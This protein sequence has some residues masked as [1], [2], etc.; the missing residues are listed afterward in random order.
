MP[1]ADGREDWGVTADD[2]G[3]SFLGQSLSIDLTCNDKKKKINFGLK[4]QSIMGLSFRIKK[5]DTSQDAKS[6]LL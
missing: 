6:H 5:K 1:G 2:H 4:D 3:V